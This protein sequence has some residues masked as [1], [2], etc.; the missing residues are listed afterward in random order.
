MEHVVG[1]ARKIKTTVG[2]CNVADHNCRE[3]VYD[4]ELQPL[5]DKLPEYI[6]H[7]ERA[8]LN[9]GDRCG[10]EAVLKRRS[11]RIAEAKLARKPQKNASAAIEFSIS[12]SP[13]WF[14][15]HKPHE[16]K[17][18]F[19]DARTLLEERYGAENIAHWATHYDEK[20]PHMH[21]LM[22]PIRE[23]S[24]GISYTS[25]RFLGGING[26]REFQDEL[27]EKVG[28]KYG[29]ERGLEGS[30]ARHTDQYE[31]AAENAKERDNLA[32]ERGGLDLRAKDLDQR[33]QHLDKRAT[34]NAKE[35]LGLEARE[36]ALER[37]EEAL[38][39]SQQA[40]ELKA[41]DQ[42]RKDLDLTAREDA[43]KRTEAA[44]KATESTL[45]QR[46]SQFEKLSEAKIEPFTLP[47][48]RKPAL[49]AVKVFTASDG[50]DN[51]SWDAFKAKEIELRAKEYAQTMAT[52]AKSAQIKAEKFEKDASLV[53]RFVERVK[54][55]EKELSKV[56]HFTPD[57]LRAWARKKEQDQQQD[58]QRGRNQGGRGD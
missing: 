48:M 38:K 15:S 19:K 55:L 16:W 4:R 41:K 51:L 23:T 54:T 50:T 26:L 8:A 5:G 32:M 18:Y 12:A 57:E 29:L 17:A 35:I 49:A 7:P 20:T 22:V 10:G 45:A 33:A 34:D 28:K 2:L 30:D 27:A 3:A 58:L 24:A 56:S 11:E 46:I 40:V 37:K 47:D 52:V 1:H 6:S 53:P 13:E 39:A 25:S 14:A 31:W 36:S 9:E 44:I 43:I 21:V 42:T